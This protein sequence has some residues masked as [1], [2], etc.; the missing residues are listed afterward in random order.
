[1]SNFINRFILGFTGPIAG[2][3]GQ[4]ADMFRNG[5]LCAA[6]FS[7]SDRV[8]ET[9]VRR[10]LANFTREILQDIGDGLRRDFGGGVIAQLTAGL[11][12][13][14]ERRFIAID[15]I[16]NPAEVEFF[17]KTPD[18]VLFSVTAPQDI[19]WDRLRQ[20]NRP[21]D[22]KT[23]EEF[24]ARD[25]RDLGIGQ[26]ALG[27]QVSRCMEMADFK[28][29]NTGTLEELGVKVAEFMAEIAMQTCDPKL[30]A[31]LE[32]FAAMHGWRG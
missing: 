14:E 12:F 29:D 17:R 27:Q 32:K 23:W 6:Y 11:A 7:L 9:A 3:K 16:R 1:M 18:F 20:R 4:V 30:S 21:S 25:A 5:P 26:D 15:G 13:M 28:I 8:R 31:L 24:L 2:G 10:G 22:P 19:R